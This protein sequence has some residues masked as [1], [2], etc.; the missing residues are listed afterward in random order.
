MDHKERFF[1][2]L[3]REQVDRPASWLGL[4]DN[5]AIPGLTKYFG[6]SDLDELRNLIDDDIYPVS[7]PYH[8]PVSDLIE[9]AFNFT[10][11]GKSD[12]EHRT[13]NSPGFFENVSDPERINDFDWPDPKKYI[14][15]EECL[16]SVRKAP[17]DKIRLGVIWSSHF[18]DVFAAF[19]M[20]NACI[21]MMMAPEMVIGVTERILNF[22]LKA[23]EIFYEATK[24]E[25]DA[26]LIG[27]D[28]GGQSG[29]MVSPEMIREF[30][31]PGTIKL[32]NQAKSYNLKIIHHSCGSIYD[33]IPDL[34]DTGVDAIHP[35]QVRAY[36][37][38]PAK[39]KHAF[40]DR[41]AFV[42]GVDAQYNLVQEKPEVIYQEVLNLKEIFPTGLVI[43]PS[44]EAV[45]PDVKPANIEAL[46]NAVNKK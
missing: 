42:G 22:Y 27:N 25:L 15:P 14:D 13:L 34:I 20:E 39:L 35:M 17:K 37:M 10:L 11:T 43:S 9:T 26:I 36:G 23:N 16:R 41:I 24:G 31:L 28:L 40:G 32:V 45:L 1:A 7:L 2:T 4:P 6:V 29:L 19:G 44:H 30:A 12:P 3:K 46:F 18:Q 5:K 38:E 21:Q 8:S 33:I